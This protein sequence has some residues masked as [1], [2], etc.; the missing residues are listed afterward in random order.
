MRGLILGLVVGVLVLLP[1][2]CASWG[3]R[4]GLTKAEVKRRQKRM[5]RLNHQ[6]MLADIDRVL[7]LDEPSK[8]TDKRI[9]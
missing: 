4:P 2:G 9:P 1:C 7:M 3:Q 5:L 8:L 6:E